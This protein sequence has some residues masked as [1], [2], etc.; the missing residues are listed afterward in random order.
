LR[1][2]TFIDPAVTVIVADKRKSRQI[3]LNLLSNACKFTPEGGRIEI[4][5]TMRTPSVV[6][7]EVSDTGVG[8][9]QRE[10]ESIFSEFHQAKMAR[11]EELGGT[12]IGLALVRRLVE[13]HGGEVGVDSKPGEGSTFWFTLPIGDHCD[14]ASI[15]T[16]SVSVDLRPPTID[17]ENC[18]VLVVDDSIVNCEL[19]LDMLSVHKC[20]VKVATNGQEAIDLAPVFNPDIIFMDI[21]MPVMDG[22]EATERIRSLS[23][24]RDTP[25]IALTANT[26]RES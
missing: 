5:A 22:R 2:T 10:V 16:Q 1:V 11:D 25:I 18:R 17:Y 3:L 6:K 24:F 12:G 15:D 19:I 8:V 9:E 4:R 20:Q 7:V 14:N 23:Q 21:R 26:G 13:L